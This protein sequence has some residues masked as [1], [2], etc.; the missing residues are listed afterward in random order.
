MAVGELQDDGLYAITCACGF[1]V[2]FSEHAIQEEI[3]CA[4]CRS[5]QSFF[6]S[7]FAGRKDADALYIYGG[8]NTGAESR[9]GEMFELKEKVCALYKEVTNGE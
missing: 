9:R 3:T 1:V 7:V 4:Y 2:C 8:L 5:E 6:R